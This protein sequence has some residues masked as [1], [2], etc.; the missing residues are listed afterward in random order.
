MK[1]N[2]NNLNE[3]VYV[4]TAKLAARVI[5]KPIRKI[6]EKEKETR[7]YNTLLIKDIINHVVQKYKLSKLSCSKFP[8]E[9]DRYKCHI[10]ILN[11][12]INDL[13]KNLNYCKHTSDESVCKLRVLQK[14][15]KYKQNI[16]E[17]EEL[18]KDSQIEYLKVQNA[19]QFDP[20]EYYGN[21]YKLIGDD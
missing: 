5:S 13:R 15:D 1:D 6:A 19:R 7:S 3:D 16:I 21:D 2:L 18:I 17:Y 14:I 20:D 11:K 9:V 8:Y 12:K 10:N 4:D